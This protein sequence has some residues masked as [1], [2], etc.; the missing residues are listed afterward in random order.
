MKDIML[1]VARL[2]RLRAT[3]KVGGLAE[4]LATT[5]LHHAIQRRFAH[6]DTSAS[7]AGRTPHR[8]VVSPEGRTLRQPRHH[9]L[10][11]TIANSI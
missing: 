1:S 11:E 3:G 5:V 10:L 7:V 2:D 9:L 6:L 4:R 8:P